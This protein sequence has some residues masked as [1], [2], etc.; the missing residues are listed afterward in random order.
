MLETTFHTSCDSNQINSIACIIA[1]VG[2]IWISFPYLDAAK[3]TEVPHKIQ[4]KNWSNTI[5]KTIQR[6]H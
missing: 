3:S 2:L 1:W 4:V 5:P 6:K